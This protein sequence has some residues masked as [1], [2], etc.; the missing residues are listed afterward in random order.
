MP[1]EDLTTLD[2]LRAAATIAVIVCHLLA[3]FGHAST[4]VANGGR[5]AVL[6]F[7]VHTCYVLM[8]SMGRMRTQHA[9]SLWRK[10]L[11]RRFFRL[12]PLPVFAMLCIIAFRIPSRML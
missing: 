4:A 1:I 11:V 8:L 5:L 2:F 10:F 6:V 3:R 7:F 12:Y 9:R